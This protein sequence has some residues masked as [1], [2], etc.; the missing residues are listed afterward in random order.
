MRSLGTIEDPDAAE[1]FVA[2]L[3]TQGIRTQVESVDGT[4]AVEIWVRDEDLLSKA[5][6]E[7]EAFLENPDDPRYAGAIP[8]AHELLEAERKSREKALANLRQVDMQRSPTPMGQGPTPLTIT[9]LIISLAVFVVTNFGE[10]GPPDSLAYKVLDSLQF[11]SQSDWQASNGN[12]AAS[13]LRGQVWRIV[14][15]I[16]VHFGVFHMAMN[17]F[18]LVSFG[19]LLERM[20]GTVRFGLMVLVLAVIPNLLQG[21]APEALQGSPFFGGISGVLFGFFG[22]VWVRS[23][24]NPW[25]GVRIPFP[26]IVILLGMLIGGLLGLFPGLHLA[27]LC[28]LGG[29]VIGAVMGFI[30]ETG[31]ASGG[32]QR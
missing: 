23:T 21:L 26:F 19:R 27:H 6:R 4:G 18:M 11:V 7:Y 28:H 8:Q 3:F 2:Y 14:T 1:R 29:L 17:A 20:L 15:P 12:P 16:F 24:L 25:L 10:G 9:L 30:S 5:Q 32:P 31:R 22:Y 13:I